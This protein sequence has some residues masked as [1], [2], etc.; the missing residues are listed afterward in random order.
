MRRARSADAH[1]RRDRAL[2]NARLAV[3]GLGVA[4]AFAA[5]GW[6]AV[7]ASWVA[8]PVAAFLGLLLAHDRVIRARDRA[9][10]SVAF[11]ERG[12]ARLEHRFAGTGVSGGSSGAGGAVKASV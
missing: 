6:H 4:L 11:Y 2:S 8:L 12:L 1:A 3:F 5:W 7:P 10:R 9:D